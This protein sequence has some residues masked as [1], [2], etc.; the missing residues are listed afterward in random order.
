MTLRSGKEV[1]GEDG[2][3]EAVLEEQPTTQVDEEG[4][5][6]VEERDSPLD[7]SGEAVLVSPK[8][9]LPRFKHWTAMTPEERIERQKSF[10][11]LAKKPS[12]TAKPQSP[13]GQTLSV[14]REGV[15]SMDWSS[16]YQ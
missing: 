10:A 6:V 8:P 15:M 5:A 9:D 13:V 11:T 2:D 12:Q 4:E 14:P 7:T 3:D 16:A 1:T